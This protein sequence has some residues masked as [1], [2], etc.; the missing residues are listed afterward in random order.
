MAE[1]TTLLGAEQVERA[2]RNISHAAEQMDMAA[3]AFADAMHTMNSTLDRLEQILRED[4]EAR[5]NGEDNGNG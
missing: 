5:S 3:R 1:Y 4:R 2:G